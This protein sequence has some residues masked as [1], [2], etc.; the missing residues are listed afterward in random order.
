MQINLIETAKE[1]VTDFLCL[2]RR[3]DPGFALQFGVVH[4]DL[5]ADRQTFGECM[6][7]GLVCRSWDFDLHKERRFTVQQ[8]DRD[9]EGEEPALVPGRINAWWM[10][11]ASAERAVVFVFHDVLL[12]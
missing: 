11:N 1:V 4:R 6:K 7:F 8:M 3:I 2:G 12:A 5:A 10:S 9:G